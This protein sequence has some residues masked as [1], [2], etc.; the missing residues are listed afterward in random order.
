M[1]QTSADA[2]ERRTH[3]ELGLMAKQFLDPLKA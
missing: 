2:Q 3:R 1:G